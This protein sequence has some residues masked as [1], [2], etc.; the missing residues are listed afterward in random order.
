MSTDK[1]KQNTQSATQELWHVAETDDSNRAE[2]LL[3]NGAEINAGNAHGMTA[4]M[5]AAAR[6]RVR[7]VR[8]LLKHGADPN[9]VRNDKFTALMLAAFFGHQEVVRILVEHGGDADATTRFGTS[10]QVWAA[11]RTFKGIVQYLEHPRASQASS[12]VATVANTCTDSPREAT[13]VKRDENLNDETPGIPTERSFEEV[14]S[15]AALGAALIEG[16]APSVNDPPRVQHSSPDFS[17]IHQFR[18]RLHPVNRSIRG[19]AWTALLLFIAVFAHLALE[20]GQRDTKLTTQT[21]SPV[22]IEGSAV[23]V[24]PSV[25]DNLPTSVAVKKIAPSDAQADKMALGDAA[26]TKSKKTNTLE[27]RLS[28]IQVL[29]VGDNGIGNTSKSPNPT[30]IS[31]STST[32][33]HTADVA[34]STQFTAV[35]ASTPKPQ[36][37]VSRESMRMNNPTPLPT[38]LITGSK[39][40]NGRVIQWP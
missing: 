24:S 7:M 28:N 3:A 14:G 5:R 8:V 26:A 25:A 12:N 38:E 20:Q 4:L 22:A 9:S 31:Q 37:A 23:L 10:A 17:A 18:S 36:P 33:E 29:S 21:H 11:S 6:G 16:V 35:A 1:A 40:P 15:L 39:T 13:S 2:S 27:P 19:Y 32:P 34:R 30:S